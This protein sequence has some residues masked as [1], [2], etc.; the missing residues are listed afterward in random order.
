MPQIRFFRPHFSN[1]PK[2][3]PHS[4]GFLFFINT[5]IFACIFIN[6]NF[7]VTIFFYNNTN[8]YFI[9]IIFLYVFI[10]FLIEFLIYYDILFLK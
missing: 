7:F 10:F 6:S 4:I 3:R 2:L 8:I 5:N 1:S 9:N